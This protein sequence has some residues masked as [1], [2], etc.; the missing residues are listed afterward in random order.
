M[1]QRKPPGVRF[2]TWIEKQIR[3]ATERGE[4]DDL[5]GYGRRIDDLA[6]EYDEDWWIKQKLRREHI[7]VLPASLL[8]RKEAE[9]T[10]IAA[11]R[12]RTSEEARALVEAVNE[13]ILE[14]IRKPIEGPPLNLFPFDVEEV[15]AQWHEHHP[16][17]EEPVVEEPVP[18]D[19]KRRLLDRFR[20]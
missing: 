14:G 10:L 5:P 6:D 17:S 13:K 8:L 7:V 15:I 2:E 19:P 1:T 12:A 3:E 18:A 16:P 9:E 20:R 11:V 4:F